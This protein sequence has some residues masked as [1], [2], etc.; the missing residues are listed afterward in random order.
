MSV[1][2]YF[3]SRG[4]DD[5]ESPFLAGQE[6]CQQAI[7]ILMI[8]PCSLLSAPFVYGVIYIPS[9]IILHTHGLLVIPSLF[10][11]YHHDNLVRL[12]ARV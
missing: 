10:S 11:E 5:G 9:V 3:L 6:S 8:D 12:R 2:Q 4:I 7:W 1:L